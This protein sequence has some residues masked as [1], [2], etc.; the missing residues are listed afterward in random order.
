MKKHI[1]DDD[2]DSNSLP[3]SRVRLAERSSLTM[4]AP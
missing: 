4:L 3:R 1:H 2:D